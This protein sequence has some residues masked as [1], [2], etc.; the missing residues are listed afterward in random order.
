MLLNNQSKLLQNLVDEQKAEQKKH[1]S[2][3]NTFQVE[4]MTIKKSF[5]LMCLPLRMH[6]EGISSSVSKNTQGCPRSL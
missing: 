2:T 4:V 6:Q 3:N 5:S 1:L